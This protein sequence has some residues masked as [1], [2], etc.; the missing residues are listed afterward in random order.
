MIDRSLQLAALAD[1]VRRGLLDRLTVDGPQTASQLAEHVTISRQA[2]LKHLGTLE[3]AGYLSR[4]TDGRSVLFVP[5]PDALAETAAWL[6]ATT[7][8]WDRRLDRLGELL[9]E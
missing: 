1:D 2:V 7:S 8:G 4:R 5:R 9:G 3:A 6:T